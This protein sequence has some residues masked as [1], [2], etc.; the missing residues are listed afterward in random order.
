MYRLESLL[1]SSS[2]EDDDDDYDDS[3]EH[4][5]RRQL[6]RLDE[7]ADFSSQICE[8]DDYDRTLFKGECERFDDGSSCP[9][10]CRVMISWWGLSAR[11]MMMMMM[12]RLLSPRDAFRLKNFYFCSRREPKDDDV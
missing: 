9:P 4:I 2:A 1:F 12:M 8:M 7:N 10:P 11:L 3:Y 6:R 5:P